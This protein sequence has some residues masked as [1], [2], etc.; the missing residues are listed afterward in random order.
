VQKE[1]LIDM[2]SSTV[3][4]LITAA[5]MLEF[6]AEHDKDFI[7]K[8]ADGGRMEV[9]NGEES[10]GKGNEC[11]GEAVATQLVQ[12]H[13]KANADLEKLAQKKG[14]ALDSGLSVVSKAKVT[15]MNLHS[16]EGF[17]KAYISAMVDDHTADVAHFEKASAGA[18]DPEVRAFAAKTLPTLRKHL[19]KAS[20]LNRAL[21]GK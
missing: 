9:E 15:K 6:S 12:D 10:A 14:I 19:Q 18:D 7:T 2:Q 13:S 3:L 8:A 21:S 20:E 4:S 5:G 11:A 17:D 1:G 16:G